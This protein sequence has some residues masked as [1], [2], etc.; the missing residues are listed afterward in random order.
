MKGHLDYVLSFYKVNVIPCSMY[1]FSI[2]QQFRKDT[3]IEEEGGKSVNGI[4]VFSLALKFLRGHFLD[5]LGVGDR[6]SSSDSL[7]KGY[8][9]RY[10]VTVPTKWDNNAKECMK[11]ACKKVR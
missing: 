2:F 1:T 3:I 10:V 4:T 8:V 5:A 7:A 11:S 6:Y 9:A